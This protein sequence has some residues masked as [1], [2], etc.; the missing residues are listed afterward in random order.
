MHYF[1]KFFLGIKL[2]VSG[3]SSVHYQE[4]FTVHTAM[5]YVIHVCWLLASRDQY[6]NAVPSWSCSQVVSKPV[7]QIPLVC[8]QWKT[9]DDGQRNCPK[10]AEFYSKNKVEKLV[11]IVGFIMRT[12]HDSR[13]PERQNIFIFPLFQKFRCFF[14][15]TLCNG[16]SP[17]QCLIKSGEYFRSLWV[18]NRSKLYLTVSVSRTTYSRV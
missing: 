18:C 13:S 14:L 8:V 1:L 9:P 10:H 5:V 16:L 4:F 12:Y 2:H 3:S 15:Q 17:L 7:W 6:R 11:Y